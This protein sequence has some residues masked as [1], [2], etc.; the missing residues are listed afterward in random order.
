MCAR[1]TYTL[2][3]AQHNWPREHNTIGLVPDGSSMLLEIHAYVSTWEQR[4]GGRGSG[5]DTESG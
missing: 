1:L 4:Q 3:W 2:S 5:C